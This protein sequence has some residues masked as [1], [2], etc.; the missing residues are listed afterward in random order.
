MLFIL[1]YNDIVSFNTKVIY[2]RV[3]AV[4]VTFAHCQNYTTKGGRQQIGFSY[5]FTVSTESLVVGYVRV[6][7]TH[8]QS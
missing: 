7:G 6:E 5:K 4:I 1:W 8:S 3:P 2:N